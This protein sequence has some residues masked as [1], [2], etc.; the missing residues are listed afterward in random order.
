[1]KDSVK[2]FPIGF[3]EI[4]EQTNNIDFNQLS[5]SLLGSLLA[6]LSA[7]KPNGRF[8]ELGTGTG[9]S[10]VCNDKRY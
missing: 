7:T 5:D 9:L 8:L 6:T 10:I 1:M 4:V 3:Q 2:A